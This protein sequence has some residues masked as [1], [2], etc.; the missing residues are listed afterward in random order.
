M[1]LFDSRQTSCTF[2]LQAVTPAGRDQ[3]GLA[4]GPTV[5]TPGLSVYQELLSDGT[6]F[7]GYIGQHVHLA[8]GWAN[9][10]GRSVQYAM[11]VQRPL[12]DPN[13]LIHR[14]HAFIGGHAEL[15]TFFKGFLGVTDKDEVIEN[16]PRIM[17]SR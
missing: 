9:G 14:A 7:Q 1:Q 17:H 16:R 3:D 10:F 2:N 13:T 8:P 11:A 5:V 12:I 15:I 4:D 6:A